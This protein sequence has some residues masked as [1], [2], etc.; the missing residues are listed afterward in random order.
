MD[1]GE[2]GPAM[3]EQNRNVQINWGTLNVPTIL[4]ILCLLWYTATHSERQD[5]RLDAIEISRAD[6]RA[7]YTK[8]IENLETAVRKQENLEYRLTTAEANIIANNTSINA[9]VDRQGDTLMDIRDSIAKLSTSFE[10]F[11]T[12]MD[13]VFPKK[14]G[15]EM[16][17]KPPTEYTR[18]E[19]TPQQ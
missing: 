1:A 10:V 18:R 8:R 17:D 9:R 2:K 13:G 3:V 19:L 15:F 6:S 11:S 12:R 7:V 14:S 5:S 16:V 4:S